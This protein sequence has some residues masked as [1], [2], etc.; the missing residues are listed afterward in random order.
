[1]LGNQFQRF[2]VAGRDGAALA[3]TRST[4][5]GQ[6]RVQW[7]VPWHL[8]LFWHAECNETFWQKLGR[9]RPTQPPLPVLNTKNETDF[10][11]KRRY[12]MRPP[13]QKMKAN[14]D[15]ISATHGRISGP[16]SVEYESSIPASAPAGPM[17]L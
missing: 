12:W 7:R 14:P 10:G 9:V 13:A 1:M 2:A 5:T 16:H 6:L 11:M 3:S 4:A 8:R 15:E 17:I